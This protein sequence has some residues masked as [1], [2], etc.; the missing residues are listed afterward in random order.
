[1]SALPSTGNGGTGMSK[2][3]IDELPVEGGPGNG[4]LQR[5]LNRQGV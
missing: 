1:M 3:T 5:A 2:E 4:A